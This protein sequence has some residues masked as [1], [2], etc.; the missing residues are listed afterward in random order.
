MQMTR[1]EVEAFLAKPYIADLATLKPDGSPHIAPVWYIYESGTF[2]ITTRPG[3]AKAKHIVRDPRVALSV[4]DPVAPYKGV[5][6]E[7][8]AELVREGAAELTRRLAVRYLGPTEGLA[9]AEAL[10]RFE[11]VVIRV[12]PLK[13]TSWD[14]AKAG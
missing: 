1:E 6:V 14:Y 11:R 9:Y 5:V 4:H 10:N 7:G 12:V 3:R 2:Y 8:K 13:M